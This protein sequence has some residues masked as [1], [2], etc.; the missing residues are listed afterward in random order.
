M[1]IVTWN[2]GGGFIESKLKYEYDLEDINY[3]INELKSVNPDIVCFQEIHISEINNQPQIIADSLGFKY[4]TTHSIADS[5]L[6]DDE[7]LSISIISRYPV[8]S[9]KFNLLTNP[10]LE[11]EWKGKKAF[12]HDKGF[13]EAII[14]YQETNIRVLSGHMV[15]FRKFGKNFLDNEF[16]E[17]RNQIEKII[18]YGKMPKI[19]CADMNFDGEIEKLIPNIFENDYKFILENI[20]TTPKGRT[21]DKIIISKDWKITNSDILNGKA[22]H[23]LC[24][25]D[26]ELK[27]NLL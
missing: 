20:P 3:F 11:F 22:D 21:Y 24:F 19:I 27:Q 23:F 4:I 17:I 13:L 5:H 14:D 9:S 12:S 15:P 16:E 26:I 6:K 7:K 18:L 2:I 1:R 10:N 25:A 8:I